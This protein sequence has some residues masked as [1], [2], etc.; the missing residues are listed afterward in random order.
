M[1]NKPNDN[2]KRCDGHKEYYIKICV[3]DDPI[4]VECED[5]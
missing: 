4:L 3:F 2:C 1:R 5:C